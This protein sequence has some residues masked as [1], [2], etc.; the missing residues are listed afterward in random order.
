M[1]LETDAPQGAPDAVVEAAPPAQAD[2]TP[3][4]A[5]GQDT[6]PES[7]AQPDDAGADGEPGKRVP[8]FQKRIDEVTRQKYDAQREAAYLRGLLEAASGGQPARQQTSGPPAQE[9][10]TSYEEYEQALIDYRVEQKLEQY[11]QNQQRETVARTFEERATK[12]RDGKPDFDA[13]VRDPSLRI[14]PTMA[15]VIQASDL[16]PN[17]AYHLGTNRSEADRIAGLPPHLQAAALG[18]IEAAI[19]AP[20]AQAPKPIAPP[21]PQTVTGLAAGV[22]KTPETMSMSEYIEWR[23]GQQ[24]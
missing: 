21:P 1:D 19:S 23:K 24:S 16:G 11:Q 22:G 15:E 14:T 13:V 4:A 20:P 7:A 9:Q 3:D 17:I 12:F 8:W 2:I 6:A 5:T 10:F 18:R